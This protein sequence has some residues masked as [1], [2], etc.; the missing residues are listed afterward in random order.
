MSEYAG[1]VEVPKGTLAKV[2]E[3][4]LNPLHGD[5]LECKLV[6]SLDLYGEDTILIS[7]SYTVHQNSVNILPN[8]K[9]T[10]LLYKK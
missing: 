5:E 6:I 9:A 10:K 3:R 4:K 2:I 7:F 1:P 8:N